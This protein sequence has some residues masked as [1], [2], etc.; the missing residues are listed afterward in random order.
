MISASTS[1]KVRSMSERA[2]RSERCPWRNHVKAIDSANAETTLRTIL[3]SRLR[4]AVISCLL[5]R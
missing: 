3:R 5:P 1:V 2:S 4:R